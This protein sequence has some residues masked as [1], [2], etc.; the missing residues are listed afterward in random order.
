MVGARRVA[1]V[2]RRIGEFGPPD[3]GEEGAPVAV[4]IGQDAGVAIARAVGAALRAEHARIAE[5]PQ[6]RVEDGAGEVLRGQELHRRLEHR[7]LHRL[8]AAA[9]LPLQQRGEDGIGDGLP[10]ELVADD[11]GD[12][13]GRGVRRPAARLAAQRREA[14]GR[15]DDVVVGRLVAVGAA[16]AEAV[17]AA[18]DDVGVDRGDRVGVE[19]QAG[20]GPRAQRVEE[21]V[22]ARHEAAQCG[23]RLL[24]LEVEDDPALVA[25]QL[26]ERPAHAG[27]ARGPKAA[28]HVALR[29]LDLDYVRAHVREDVGRER[30]HDDVG[31]VEDA[32]A[33]Q[34]PVA[35]VLRAAAARATPPASSRDAG[36]R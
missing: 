16:G 28:D 21:H 8:P 29:R 17:G 4:R 15:L 36:H 13:G 1:A 11:A 14:G 23:A 18:I 3:E 5:A 7:R 32:D 24:R 25:V 30:P 20:D 12:V 33:G 6:R 26:E 9:A 2:A 31:E 19:A 27:V 35:E 10:G 34:R 22:G